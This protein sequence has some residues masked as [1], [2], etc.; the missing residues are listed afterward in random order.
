MPEMQRRPSLASES[1]FSF[2]VRNLFKAI[3]ARMT[4]AGYFVKMVFLEIGMSHIH[5]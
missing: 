3:W 4:C 1:F 5:K 2:E